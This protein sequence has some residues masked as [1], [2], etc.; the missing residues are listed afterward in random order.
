MLRRKTSPKD[1]RNNQEFVSRKELRK[2]KKQEIL[3]GHN[4]QTELF[5]KSGIKKLEIY[6]LAKLSLIHLFTLSIGRKT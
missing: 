1:L 5:N 2:Q 6:N 3:I 4:F